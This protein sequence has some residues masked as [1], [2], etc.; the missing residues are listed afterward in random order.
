MISI[1][2]GILK[3]NNN[4]Y[5]EQNFGKCQIS[6]VGITVNYNTDSSKGAVD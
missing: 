4:I 2:I 1:K 5:G 3:F 6:N